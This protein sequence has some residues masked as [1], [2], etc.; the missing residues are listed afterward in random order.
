MAS[1]T[2]QLE[3]LDTSFLSPEQKG[4]YE[5]YQRM[6]GSA[7]WTLMTSRFEEE[8][9]AVQTTYETATDLRA[10]GYAQGMRTVYRRIIQYPNLV[11]AYFASLAKDAQDSAAGSD[12]DFPEGG[13]DWA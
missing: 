8:A 10:L 7:G 9:L 12:T 4:E 6:F 3:A 2:M 5:A 1:E 13:D 11:E